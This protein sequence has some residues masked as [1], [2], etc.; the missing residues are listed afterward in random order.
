VDDIAKS[1]VLVNTFVYVSSMKILVQEQTR[2]HIVYPGQKT[3]RSK[4]LESYMADI[5]F[6]TKAWN[7]F[8][9][10]NNVCPSH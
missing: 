9:F 5:D 10:L 1:L 6:L 2:K 7:E 8:W 4:S 3:T